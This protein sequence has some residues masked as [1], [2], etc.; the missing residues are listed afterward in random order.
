MNYY[1]RGT[2]SM[3]GSLGQI[4]SLTKHAK[5]QKNVKNLSSQGLGDKFLNIFST[6]RFD[7]VIFSGLSNVLAVTAK[8]LVF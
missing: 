5:V 8:V 1:D 7:S 6:F 4:E 2:F 3:T